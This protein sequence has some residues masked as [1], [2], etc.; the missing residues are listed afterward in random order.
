VNH[1]DR[2]DGMLYAEDVPLT[3]IANDVGTPVYI[4]SRATFERHFRVFDEA[5]A[6]V[7]HLVCFAVKACS[8]IAILQLLARLGSG[9]DIVSEGELARVLHAGGDPAKIVFS[10][11]GKT[12][13]EMEKALN[14]GILCFNVE[15]V[16]ELHQLAG[17]ACRLGVKAPVSLRINPN[18]DP[19]THPYIATG[20]RNNKFGIEWEKAISA[21]QEA[22]SLEGLNVVGLDCH[23]GSQISDLKPMVEAMGRMVELLDQLKALGLDIEHLDIGGGLG[24]TYG[25]EVP[26]TPAAYA[27]KLIGVL[28]DR[29]LRIVAEP[30]RV[31]AGN[32]GVLVTQ[33]LLTKEN[34]GKRFVVVDAGMNDAIRPA[35]YQAWHGIEPVAEARTEIHEVDV[36]GP[37]CE[38]GDF[39]AQNRMM[40]RVEAG[41]LL[42]MQS[43][44]AYGF[45]MAS[46]YNSR[47][48]V[49]EVLVDGDQWHV[50]RERE[51]IP[52]LYALEHLLPVD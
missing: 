22:I 43:A 31:I 30:G 15:S 4:Y 46:N 45:V 14:A 36:V 34:H 52:S 32:A 24:I 3:R 37:I 48:R 26:P 44:G 28:G 11:V 13:R 23:I 33:V 1:F 9:F 38:S 42:C 2:I 16:A 5:F 7:D 49:A 41:E 8:N 39:L 25:D 51:S 21:Y 40:P 6:E 19:K 27:K 50:I 47:P 10:G 18:V 17:V 29:R 35:L 20:L 12:E